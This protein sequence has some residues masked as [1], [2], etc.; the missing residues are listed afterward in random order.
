MLSEKY[1]EETD[2]LGTLKVPADVLYGIHAMRAR[3]NF[4]D[5]T[6]FHVEWYKAM[7]LVKLAC[8]KAYRQFMVAIL[9]RKNSQEIPFALL[10]A[11]VLDALESAAAEVSE[12]KHFSAFIVPCLLYTSR[13][14]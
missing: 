5:R 2:S 7:G 9:E 8:Y 12:G 10:D 6:L 13:C 14:V 4:P 1:R 11:A 3:E